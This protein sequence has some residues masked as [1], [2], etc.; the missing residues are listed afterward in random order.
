MKYYRAEHNILIDKVNVF[1]EKAAERNSRT[2]SK[3][4]EMF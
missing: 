2:L 1:S 4:T 3:V